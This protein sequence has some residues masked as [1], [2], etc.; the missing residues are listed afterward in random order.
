MSDVYLEDPEPNLTHCTDQLPAI[1][2]CS[3][4]SLKAIYSRSQKTADDALKHAG[5]DV[6]VYFDS[7]ASPSQNLEALLKRSDIKAVII[8]VPILAQPHLIKTAMAAGKHILSEKPIAKDVPTA[9]ELLAFHQ[10]FSKS[11]V[12][13][14]GENFRFWPSV[15]IAFQILQESNS[16]LVAFSVN[17]HTLV[18]STDKYFQTEW[19]VLYSPVNTQTYLRRHKL[20]SSGALPQAIKVGFSLMVVFTS[21]L[22]YAIFS[23][24]WG[25]KLPIYQLSRPCCKKGCCRLIQSIPS[26]RYRTGGAEHSAS[27]SEWSFWIASKLTLL[28]IHVT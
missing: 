6:D 23:A 5:D 16:E 27:P 9:R 11:V 25:R 3:T 13:A 14:V 1:K 2:A 26:W 10:P 15:N 22:F 24:P 12:W 21:L 19:Y 4:L 28:R 17:F 8:A 7:L 18:D 20:K